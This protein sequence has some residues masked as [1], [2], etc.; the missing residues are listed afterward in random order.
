MRR[1]EPP[2]IYSVGGRGATESIVNMQSFC[3]A[4]ERGHEG[5]CTE[6]FPLPG[7]SLGARKGPRK[8]FCKSEG[9]TKM[10]TSSIDSIFTV[11]RGHL[12]EGRNALKQKLL[13]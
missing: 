10:A 11:S 5:A 13:S 4:A 9:P 1:P 7:G 2:H 3:F 12:D 8:K 6:L